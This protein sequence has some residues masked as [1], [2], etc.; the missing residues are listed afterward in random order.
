MADIDYASKLQVK[1]KYVESYETY[2]QMLNTT[3]KNTQG[4][5]AGRKDSAKYAQG[6]RK[7]IAGNIT[8][9]FGS[10]WGKMH[11]GIDI[12]G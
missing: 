9:R 3:F 8:S 12:Q 7:P 1:E 11:E 10:R 4:A 5:N 6:L 2:K